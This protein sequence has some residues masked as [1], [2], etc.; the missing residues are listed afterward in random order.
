MEGES[1]MPARVPVVMCGRAYPRNMPDDIEACALFVAMGDAAFF[2]D[3][4]RMNE[5]AV[6]SCQ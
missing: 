4:G 1:R 3:P 2:T 6:R 5:V